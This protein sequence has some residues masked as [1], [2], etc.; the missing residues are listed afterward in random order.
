M[1]FRSLIVAAVV[2]LVLSGVLYWSQRKKPAADDN[3]TTANKSPLIL[4]IISPAN[5]TTLTVKQKGA[6]PVTLTRSGSQWQITAP[7]KLPADSGAVSSMLSALAP[8][9]SDCVVEDKAASLAPYGLSDPAFEVDVSTKDGRNTQLL[10]GDDTPTADGLYATRSGDPRVFTVAEYAKTSLDKSLSDLRDKRLVPVDSSSVSS[11]DLTR[12][13]EDIRFAR[14]QN[15]WHIEKPQSYR[16]DNYE[17]NDLVQQLTSAKWDSSVSADDAA[18]AFAKAAPLATVNLTGG[19]GTYILDVRKDKDDT[20]AKSSAVAGTWKIDS[21]SASSL[22]QDLGRS[23]DDFRSKQLFDFGYTDP[24]QIEYHSGATAVVLTH[25]GNTW[26]SNGRKMDTD[27][28]EGVVSALRELSAN[29]FVTSGFTAPALD[30]TVTSNRGQRVEK[31]E[32][33]KTSDGG[34]AKREDDSSLYSLDSATI[35]NLTTAIA[36]LKPAGPPKK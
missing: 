33:A 32:I 22:D 31:V 10:F 24:D 6:P 18:K 4:N 15:G 11:I 27:S 8:L 36:S 7:Q 12:K 35:N 30:V 21:S 2:L 3:I 25:A 34:I 28:V 17:V 1:K 13:G 14:V 26:L 16:P 19:A 9:A 23:L 29:K 20:Y 5:A